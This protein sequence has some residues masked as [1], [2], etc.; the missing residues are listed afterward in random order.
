MHRGLQLRVSM[1]LAARTVRC[2]SASV[3]RSTDEVASSRMT[4]AGRMSSARARQSSWRSPTLIDR[5]LALSRVSSPPGKRTPTCSGVGLGLG[6]G[7]GWA[8]RAPQRGV[9][10]PAPTSPLHLPYISPISPLYLPYISHA[11]LRARPGK[12]AVVL[13]SI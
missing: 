2:M 6:L 9:H 3:S 1:G 13:R 8:R 4:R 5:P 10:P 11:H 7:L 12:G